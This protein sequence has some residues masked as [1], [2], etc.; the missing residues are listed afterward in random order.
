MPF[1]LIFIGLAAGIPLLFAG[2]RALDQLT[3]ALALAAV[4]GVLAFVALQFLF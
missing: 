2:V 1:F 3:N 4:G